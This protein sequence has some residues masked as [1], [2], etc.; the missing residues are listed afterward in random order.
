MFCLLVVLIKSSLLA[1]W[2]TRKTPLRKP[3]RGEGI[4]SIKPRPKS[5]WLSWFI[6]SSFVYF[7]NY[8]LFPS[9]TPFPFGCI[10]F[11]VLVMRKGGESSWSGPWHLGCTLEVFHVHRCQDQ[12]I[13]PGWAECFCVF[14]LGLCFVCSFCAF[15]FVCM[16]PFFCVSLGSWV[17][18]L[19]IFGASVTNLNEPPR[20]LAASTI[21]WVRS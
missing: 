1:K 13:Q 17:I 4:I 9:P 16:S 8:L 3:N 15:W 21:A 5:V 10:C 12:F 7:H 18:S 20:A 6:Y 2:L 19:T 14:N 11:V